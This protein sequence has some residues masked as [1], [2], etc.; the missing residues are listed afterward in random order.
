MFSVDPDE[1]H[2]LFAKIPVKGFTE[3]KVLKY[4]FSFLHKNILQR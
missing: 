4:D 2:S 1:M 3:Y